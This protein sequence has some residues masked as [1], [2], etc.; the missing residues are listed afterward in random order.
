[1]HTV[2]DDATHRIGDGAGE[3]ERPRPGVVL[4][5][6]VLRWRD[7]RQASGYVVE[8][9]EVRLLLRVPRAPVSALH[10][11]L[12]L[13]RMAT[14]PV[15]VIAV[16]T[17]DEAAEPAA[18][19]FDI[20]RPDDR[21]ALGI[22]AASF[23][24]VVEFYDEAYE[25]IARREVILPLAPNV[26]YVLALADEHLAQIPLPRRSYESAVAAWRAP[27]F[28]R[29]G[30]REPRLEEDS[31]A[32]L[33]SATAAQKAIGVVAGWSEPEN[34]DYL[35]LT[36]SFPLEHWR[37]IRAR[38]I[39]RALELGLVLPAVLVEVALADGLVRSRK[40]VC[41]RTLA[42]FTAL[43]EARDKA[44]DLQPD[45]VAENWR[46]LLA[47]CEEEGVTVDPRALELARA[48]GG[49]SA[50]RS[51]VIVQPREG[52][53]GQAMVR[54]AATSGRAR[55]EETGRIAVPLDQSRVAERPAARTDLRAA[56]ATALVEL[57]D[58]KDA[59]LGAALELCRRVD[60]TAVGPVFGALRRMA[61]GEAVRVLPAVVKF[62]ERAVPHL[63]DGLRSR[64]AYL[65]QG[66]ALA[67]G[68]LKS[69]DGIDPLCELLLTE[70]TDVW[71]EIARALG[72]IGGGAVM[73]LAA[74]LRDP[75][76]DLADAR[77][78]IAWAMAH[79]A[80]KG[81]RG[82]VEAV[83]SGRDALAAG[84][85]RRALEHV[86]SARDNDAEV[87]GPS[88]P[89]DQ[90]V[91]RAFS[92]RFFESMGG[93]APATDDLLREGPFTDTGSISLDEE[94]DSAEILVDDDLLDGSEILKEDQIAVREDMIVEDEDIV[95]G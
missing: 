75:D 6:A 11:R 54:P 42:S 52:S 1:M 48:G 9:G 36:R 93:V 72:E 77:E 91:N 8:G 82:P 78:R 32:L 37:K 17:G 63:V 57:L 5:A 47:L 95:S 21:R 16:L 87:R 71:K 43:V 50:V 61:R 56:P 7:G 55:G 41:T 46:G 80:A 2:V 84:A 35:L 49:M 19:C 44:L 24:L 88:A 90:T 86:A 45:G 62:G 59:R 4:D 33:P 25:P 65:R 51:V 27:S 3:S 58:D 40:E 66:C 53:S 31:F 64:K 15:V 22:L 23:H 73:S 68:V 67:L 83:A 94:L 12:Q 30:R 76:V 69:G 38:V 70:P 29:Y 20:E 26:R 34:E 85:A 74:R 60:A 89:H 81:G 39:Q 18:V 92:R 79:I 13:H 10:V 28:E 14:Y